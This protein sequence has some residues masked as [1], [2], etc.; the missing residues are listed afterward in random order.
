MGAGKDHLNKPRPL[1][2][3]QD[4]LF[5][6]TE[7]ITV[8]PTTT[9]KKL[10]SP[11]LRIQI[12]PGLSGLE[13]ISYA[14]IDKIGTTSRKKLRRYLGELPHENMVSI[15]RSIMVFLGIAG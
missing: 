1:I 7:S 11:L 5:D 4:N 13:E 15:E 9:T 3:I 10:D 12:D 6:L 8:I 2:I 14:M